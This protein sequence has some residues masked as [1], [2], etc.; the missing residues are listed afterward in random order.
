M[1]QLELA[2][3][4]AET[5]LAW[6]WRRELAALEQELDVLARRHGVARTA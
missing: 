2:V 4:E 5:Q 6:D 1:S 3:R